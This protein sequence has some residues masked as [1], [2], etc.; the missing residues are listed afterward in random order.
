[1]IEGVETDFGFVRYSEKT[2]A[3]LDRYAPLRNMKKKRSKAYAHSLSVAGRVEFAALTCAA[4]EFASSGN[5]LE[6]F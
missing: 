2:L 4:I 3:Y 5:V 6:S 1:V